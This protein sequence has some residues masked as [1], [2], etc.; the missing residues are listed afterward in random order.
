MSITP[1]IFPCLL[2]HDQG[3]VSGFS[4]SYTLLTNTFLLGCLIIILLGCK[5]LLNTFKDWLKSPKEE[6]VKVVT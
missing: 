4:I 5:F 3:R 1:L 2:P 6:Y